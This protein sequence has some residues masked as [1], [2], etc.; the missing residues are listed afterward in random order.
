MPPRIILA[1]SSP[2]RAKLLEEAGIPFDIKAPDVDE[3]SPKRKTPREVAVEVATRKANAIKESSTWVLAADTVVDHEGKVL[4]KPADEMEAHAMLRMLSGS[5][6]HVF[7]GLALRPPQGELVTGSADTTVTFR[8]LSDE[9]I[10]A[11]VRTGDTLDKAGAYGIQ[12]RAKAFVAK[13]DGPLDNVIG[14]PM[15][16]VKRLLKET[17][18]PF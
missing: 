9:E 13:I 11:Y 12:G 8:E 6:H 7:T 4:G 5:A 10:D 2:R 3:R 17:G 1:S 14:L 18:Y 16:V 15:D